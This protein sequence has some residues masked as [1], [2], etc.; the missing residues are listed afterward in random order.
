MRLPL[1][2][3]GKVL[4]IDYAIADQDDKDYMAKRLGVGGDYHLCV[5]HVP[6]GA[7]YGFVEIDLSPDLISESVYMK[8][9][10]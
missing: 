9:E 1:S 2:I 5:D 6:D 8:F 4:E 10:K 3:E 7:P